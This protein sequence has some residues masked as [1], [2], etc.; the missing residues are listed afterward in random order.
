MA[1][2]YAPTTPQIGRRIWLGGEIIAII[3]A[4]HGP[5]RVVIKLD[6]CA[7]PITIHWAEPDDDSIVYGDEPGD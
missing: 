7:H 6:A 4:I 5:S 1:T 2:G 3:Q